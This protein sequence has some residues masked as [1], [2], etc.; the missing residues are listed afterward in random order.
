[1]PANSGWL[2]TKRPL[3]PSFT[4]STTPRFLLVLTWFLVSCLAGGNVALAQATKPQSRA[5]KSTP[6]VIRPEYYQGLDLL[7]DGQTLEA[8]RKFEDAYSQARQANNERGIDSIPPL[9]MMGDC[10]LHQGDIGT[11]LQYYDAALSISVRTS[12]W[13]TLLVPPNANDR[14]ENRPI[15][16]ALWGNSN[17][18]NGGYVAGSAAWTVAIGG[19]DSLPEVGATTPGQ[20]LQVDVLEVLRCQGI[21][22]RRRYRLLGPLT[23]YNPLTASL[24]QAFSTPPN[25]PLPEVVQ[26][27]AS[28]CSS[29]ATLGEYP[30]PAIV[31]RLQKSVALT[32]GNEHPLTPTA[33]LAIADIAVEGNDL[34]TAESMAF[35]A[36]LSAARGEL[37]DQ[38][39]EALELWSMCA[40]QNSREGGQVAK[41]LQQVAKWAQPRSRLVS[42]RSQIETVRQAALRGEVDATKQQATA[43]VAMFLPPQLILPRME[44]VI[45][46]AQSRAA[47]LSNNVPEGVDKLEEALVLLRGATPLSTASPPLYQLNLTLRLLADNLLPGEVGLPLLS[48]ILDSERI[49]SWRTHVLEQLVFITT[50]TLEANRESVR[51]AIATNDT[52]LQIDAWERWKAA[53]IKHGSLLNGRLSELRRGIH[54]D[55]SRVSERDRGR[56]DGLRKGLPSLSK[57]A[58]SL[59][60]STRAYAANPKWDLRRWSDEESKRWDAVLRL[61]VAQEALLWATAIAPISVPET[62][63]PRWNRNRVYP[64]LGKEDVVLAYY[65]MNGDL[66]GYLISEQEIRGWQ[67][68]NP[69]SLQ[70][71]LRQLFE[72]LLSTYP[73]APVTF[74]ATLSALRSE[75]IPD[76]AWEQLQQADRWVI[77]PDGFLWEIPFEVIPTDSAR[78]YMPSVLEHRIVYVP[79]LGTI[80]SLIGAPAGA[81]TK[82]FA[83][84]SSDFWSESAATSKS[85]MDRTATLYGGANTLDRA[86]STNF[87]SPVYSKIATGELISLVPSRWVEPNQLML[88]PSESNLA[89]TIAAWNPLPWGTPS[90]VWLL[91]HEHPTAPARNVVEPGD[92]WLRW[93]ISL[94]TQG[95]DH[96]WISRWKVGGESTYALLSVLQESLEG[97]SFTEG[98]QRAVATLWAEE[99]SAGSE[100]LLQSRSRTP[101]SATEVVP[102]SH[103]AFW[104]GYMSIGDPQY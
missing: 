18:K 21:A 63:T 15:K 35:D 49:G 33:C 59:E 42:L 20:N 103:P 12:R 96:I 31:A 43:A 68:T 27:A 85:L 26:V 1:M 77:S 30:A 71:S 39:E 7:A 48:S 75:W 52:E 90:K 22:L 44:A 91:G 78:D 92:E 60:E 100:P 37:H 87:P 65:G 70:G 88:V 19:R 6:N 83:I 28:I 25:R 38:V 101:L 46:Y 81:R 54:G 67:V 40:F 14:S 3:L 104:G 57:N 82:R 13:L 53:R 61:S 86:A 73:K 69:Q 34:A 97:V 95:T 24:P 55:R 72:D 94:G 89:G 47:F 4:M 62:I 16:D 80:P 51:L 99:L 5:S 74:A 79:T 58:A 45:P 50:D 8:Y 23:K 10:M 56:W 66:Y 93:T 102:G 32:S 98:W 36:S 11:A 84:Q 29:L 9:V 41:T 17:S 64:P 2:L 76:A